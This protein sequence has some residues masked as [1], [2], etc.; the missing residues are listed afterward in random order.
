MIAK[1]N[2][3]LIPLGRAHRKTRASSPSGR[4]ESIPSNKYLAD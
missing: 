4:A 2:L 1:A 3:K